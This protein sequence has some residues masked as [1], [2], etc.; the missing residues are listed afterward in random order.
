MIEIRGG[1]R[2][3]GGGAREGGQRKGHGLDEKREESS[4][5]P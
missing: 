5:R 2:E 1:K 3:T 4:Y